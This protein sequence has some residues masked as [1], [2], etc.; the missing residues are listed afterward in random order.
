MHSQF[1]ELS[2]HFF[3]HLINQLL[4]VQGSQGHCFGEGEYGIQT[5][6][7]TPLGIHG[8]E[9]WNRGYG[10]II[11]CQIGLPYR[12]SLKE[13]KATEVLFPDKLG[14]FLFMTAIFIGICGNHKQLTQSLLKAMGS[15]H[16]VHPGQ[17]FPLVFCCE[18]ISI[19]SIS[20]F[21][22]FF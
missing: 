20:F 21:T 2:G 16:T 15:E 6:V 17:L 12:A 18:G 7:D 13:N 19:L 10:L 1:F 4:P 11:I 3:P 14:N 8:N 5:H 22:G 9:Q